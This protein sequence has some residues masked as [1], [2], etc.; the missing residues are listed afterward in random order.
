[1]G[2]TARD[3]AFASVTCRAASGFNATAIEDQ[4]GPA[5]SNLDVER[6]AE[7]GGDRQGRS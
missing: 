6:G 7:F 4:L 5:V 2:F 3:L 1:M